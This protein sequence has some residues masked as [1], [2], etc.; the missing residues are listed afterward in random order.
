MMQQVRL[1]IFSLKMVD[2]S[3]SLLS[4]STWDFFACTVGGT[5]VRH[6]YSLSII[7]GPL[8]HGLKVMGGG[9]GLQ[10][11]SVSP[12]PL[13]FS[14][15]GF[16]G[17]GFGARAW[18]F[19]LNS[20]KSDFQLCYFGQFEKSFG[21]SHDPGSQTGQAKP[22]QNILGPFLGRFDLFLGQKY[23]KTIMTKL[24]EHSPSIYTYGPGW[25][26]YIL[27]GWANSCD[28]E[29]LLTTCAQITKIT[30]VFWMMETKT[31]KLTKNY[32]LCL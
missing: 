1:M 18:Q 5:I 25:T 6:S 29:I 27:V 31:V 26:E 23:Q 28:L 7:V 8:L 22:N 9:G 3:M 16:W 12:G 32:P 2:Y 15:F 21:F 4:L 11:F 17:L 20:Q 24:S 14:V 19:L 10:H 30:K 13:G